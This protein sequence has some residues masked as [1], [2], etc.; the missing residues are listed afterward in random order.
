MY[1]PR[2]MALVH[3]DTKYKYWLYLYL[4]E[5]NKWY[6]NYNEST[7]LD[8]HNTKDGIYRK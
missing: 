2:Y 4:T 8:Y 1:Y 3:Q 6:Y 5:R 7:T